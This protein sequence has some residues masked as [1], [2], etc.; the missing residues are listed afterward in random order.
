M[1]IFPPFLFFFLLKNLYLKIGSTNYQTNN[2]ISKM[3]VIKTA[4]LENFVHIHK[5]M[6]NITV[7]QFYLLKICLLH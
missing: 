7:R 4:D 2:T 6:P 3:V 5:I 1:L